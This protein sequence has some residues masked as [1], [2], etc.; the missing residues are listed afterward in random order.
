MTEL[1]NQISTELE[2]AL[3]EETDYYVSVRGAV[4][5][6]DNRFGL[7]SDK[8]IR[9]LYPIILYYGLSFFIVGVARTGHAELQ[10]WKNI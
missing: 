10:I 1:L 9:R 8:I 7:I 5:V 3:P 2:N 4:I 6:V